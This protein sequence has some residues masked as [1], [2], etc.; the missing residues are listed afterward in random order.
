[1]A[2][3]IKRV[4][5]AFTAEGT[6]DFNRDLKEVNASIQENRSEFKLAKSA[7]DD[8]TDAMDKLRDTQKYLANQTKDYSDKVKTLEKELEELES[9]ENK[10]ETAIS[11]KKTQ[12]NQAKTSLNN[13]QKS[14]KD[15]EK[16][17]ESGAKEHKDYGKALE[18]FGEKA[19]NTGDKLSGVSTAAA[20]VAGAVVALV[21]A[22]EEYRKIMASLE[23]SSELAGYSA[24]QT[25]ETYTQLFGVL[26]DDQTA[27]TTTANLQALGLSQEQLTELTNGTIGAW[28][29]YGDSIPIDGLAE[30]INHTVKLGEV[31]GTLADVLEWAGISTDDFNA[32][33]ATCSTEAERADAIM[34]MLAE[35]GL[36]TAGEK[37][38]TN[39]EEIVK[40]NE[41]TANFQD[42]TAKLA[43][44]V[45]PVVTDITDLVA[46]LIGKFTELPESTQK[47]I[48]GMILL[49][50]ALAP[51]I[52]GIGKLSEGVGKAM[53]VIQGLWSLIK[54]HPF[55]AVITI[56]TAVVG[57]IIWLYENCEWFREGVDK[58]IE[59]VI[60]FF[61]EFG[62]KVEE[63][64][65]NVVAKFEEIRSGI[66]EKTESAKTTINNA[67][68]KIKEYFNLETMKENVLEKFDEIK[69]GIKN[70]IE[71]ARDKVDNAIKK[72]KGFF[73]FDWSLPSL[74]MPHF[75]IKGEFSWG[76]P[77]TVPHIGV[78]WYA[79]AMSN[80][81]ILKAPTILPTTD[82]KLIG[83]GEA[84]PEMIGGVNAI[85]DMFRQAVRDELG[86]DTVLYA[87]INN[88]LDGKKI[89]TDL[90]ET[91]VKR[92][93]KKQI[94]KER[95]VG[96]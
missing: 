29:K 31:Q 81:M 43:E 20:G 90:T 80:P 24:E 40:G 54:A 8:A 26:G 96:A 38:R 11:K 79:K 39:N 46:D 57:A 53:P 76:P 66:S 65:E 83:A 78:D 61:T 63:I 69:N 27:A 85:K 10:N 21:P 93:S 94:S 35:Q 52:S 30:G 13:Y 37:W 22:T 56:I 82:G 84:G 91:V 23:T 17:L 34:Q 16:K 72:I 47:V 12:I 4:G 87:V 1:M 92:I 95:A 32:K 41:A 7:W 28:A 89:A 14:L 48:G 60:G 33:L 71:W 36:T 49:V 44:T 51:T 88:F 25:K 5:L 86:E 19:N 15:V 59:E 42:A 74:K 73:D 64:K 3:D 77:P 18:E 58:I 9:S 2:D 70:K 45:A 50:A 75:S 62:N 68:K 6:V 55:A 67:V